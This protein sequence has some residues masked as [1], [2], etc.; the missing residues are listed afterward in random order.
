MPV[1]SK[2]ITIECGFLLAIL[3]ANAPAENRACYRDQG[4]KGLIW[5]ATEIADREDLPVS[6]SWLLNQ[7]VYRSTDRPITRDHPIPIRDHSRESAIGILRS[8]SSVEIS[9]KGFLFE[10]FPELR[11]LLLQLRHFTAQ[12]RYLFFH[13]NQPFCIG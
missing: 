8:V 2:L 10:L 5:L 1:L 6:S 12:C 13:L 4:I 3:A 11:H 9:G 7:R